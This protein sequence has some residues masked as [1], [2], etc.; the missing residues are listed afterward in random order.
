MTDDLHPDSVDDELRR[1]FAAGAP[2]DPDPDV[3]LAEM[4]PGLQR[5]RMRRRASIATVLGAAAVVVLVLLV[6]LSNSGGG[7]SSVRTPPASH[8][9][10]ITLP[11]APTTAPAGGSATPD[12][13]PEVNDD[14]G[15]DTASTVPAVTS[16]ANAAPDTT[17]TTLAQIEQAAYSSDGG[18]ITVD[19]VNGQVSLTSSAPAAG[20]TAEV[21][22]NGPTRVEVRFDN[23]QTE[24][25]IRVDVV[26]GQLVPEVSQH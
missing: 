1:R 11:P 20:Y 22:D 10:R 21:H 16:P 23:G 25:R 13:V 9:P 15:D 3:V 24:W 26:N 14:H 18:S 6:V 2:L 12:S 4:R 8:A 17:P 5:A 7:S 19:F